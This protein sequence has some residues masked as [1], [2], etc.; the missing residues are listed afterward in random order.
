MR[1][2]DELLRDYFEHSYRA[3]SEAEKAAFCEL[4]RLPD[5]DLARYLVTGQA[6]ASG[7][8]AL[9]IERIRSRAGPGD[10]PS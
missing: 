9:V 3:S 4:L 6:N 2:L 7:V 8:F 1:E 5:P 10:P